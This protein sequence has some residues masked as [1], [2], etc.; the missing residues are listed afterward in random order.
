MVS[1]LQSLLI[2]FHSNPTLPCRLV[3]EQF[4][5]QEVD[6]NELVRSGTENGEASARQGNRVEN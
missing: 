6:I 1:S 2:E 5:E 4:L 3:A